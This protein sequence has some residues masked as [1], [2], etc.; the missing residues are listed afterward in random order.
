[1]LGKVFNTTQVDAYADW[2]LGEVKKQLPPKGT[3]VKKDLAQRAN[4]LN[5]RIAQRTVEF[6]K[7]EKLNIYKKAR[8]TAR[9]RE[10]MAAQG[11][12]E[13]FIKSFSLDLL[14]RVSRA[15]KPEPAK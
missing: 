6:A 4:L 2:V 13:P 14:A 9:V 8:L 12:P 15:K 1:M 10:G 3:P 5:Q 11:Y 7:T